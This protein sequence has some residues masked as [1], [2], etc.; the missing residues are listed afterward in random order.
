MAQDSLCVAVIN[1]NYIHCLMWREWLIHSGI[2]A[3]RRGKPSVFLP[4]QGHYL[5]L[6]EEVCSH[7][8]CVQ[9]AL[10]FIFD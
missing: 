1:I 2:E 7:T 10:G 3:E 4:L 6:W 5:R 9:G 8:K